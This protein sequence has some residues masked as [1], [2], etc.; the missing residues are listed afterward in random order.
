MQRREFGKSGLI[1]AQLDFF[2]RKSGSEFAQE[3]GRNSAMDEN[4]FDRVTNAG[5]LRLG[6]RHDLDRHVEIGGAIDVDDADAIGVFDHRHPG[7]VDHRLDQCFSA[8]GNDQID[9]AIHF[10]HVPHGRPIGPRNEQNAIGRTGRP[11]PR[12]VG[13]LLRSRC[14]N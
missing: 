13:A 8:A 2:F 4:G 7:G 5:S 12:P 3:L 9:V 6:V 1:G 10:R 14:W 11:W